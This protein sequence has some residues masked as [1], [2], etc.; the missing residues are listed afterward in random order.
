MKDLLKK[1]KLNESN[2]SMVLGILVIVV[3]G[4][5]IFN[6][7]KSNEGDVPSETATS[8]TETQTTTYTVQEGDSLSKI[9][10]E[11]Y[12]DA[13]RW[14]AIAETNNIV[15]PNL[16]EAG[17]ELVLPAR[18][19]IAERMEESPEDTG[20]SDEDQHG[21]ETAEAV[22]E[23]EEDQPVEESAEETEP[24][25]T[26][27]EEPEE[28]KEDTRPEGNVYEVQTGDY[29]W[30]IAVEVYGDGHRWVDIARA[31]DLVNPDVIHTGNRLVLPE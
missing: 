25:A 1:I 5:L 19:R 16:L 22:S 26:P 17:Q 4:I 23:P 15:N 20:S 21:K 31:N 27:T 29:L 30:S 14:I 7:F 12:D 11:Y 8:E 3:V 2:I 13:L 10:E 28:E 9:A 18:E 6:Y 24:T